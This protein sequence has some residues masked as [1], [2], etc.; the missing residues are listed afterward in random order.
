M[1]RDLREAIKKELDALDGLDP[2]NG[3]TAREVLEKL[4]AQAVAERLQLGERARSLAQVVAQRQQAALA[5][6]NPG[7]ASP[8]AHLSVDF[9]AGAI[10]SADV[11]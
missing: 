11:L 4:L 10:D 7:G 1:S 6:A 2:A 8:G 5:A 9:I 3:P